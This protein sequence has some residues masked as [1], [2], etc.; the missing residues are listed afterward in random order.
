MSS[1]SGRTPPDEWPERDLLTRAARP[2]TA[3]VPEG[4]EVTRIPWNG[5]V[6]V[7]HSYL[8]PEYAF[9]ATTS[10]VSVDGVEIARSGGFSF[11]EGSSG[12]FVDGAGVRHTVDVSFVSNLLTVHRLQASVRID[13]ATVWSGWHP[14]AQWWIVLLALL[15]LSTAGIGLLILLLGAAAAVFSLKG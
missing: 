12:F 10:T 5:H 15:V 6:L 13:G 7:L 1:G 3:P 4:A 14:I 8:A 11:N 9:F 2:R